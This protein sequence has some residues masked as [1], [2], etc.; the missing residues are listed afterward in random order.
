M[1]IA[2]ITTVMLCL[3]L[4]GAVYTFTC[5]VAKLAEVAEAQVEIRA[6]LS[7]KVDEKALRAI[8]EQL[9]QIPGIQSFEYISKEKALERM[10][11]QFGDKEGLLDGIDKINPLPASFEIKVAEPSMLSGVAETVKALSGID[12]VDYQKELVDKLLLVTRTMRFGSVLVVVGL[13]VVTIFL[14]ANTIRLTVYARRKEIA[15]MKLVGATDSLVRIPLVL[16]GVLLG[17]VGGIAAG[18]INNVVYAYVFKTV[19]SSMPFI[20]LVLPQ[21][22]NGKVL[23]ITAG[24]GI[25]IGMV[26][27]VV[28]M[29]RFLRI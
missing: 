2:S 29:R 8:Q 19:S 7:P 10:K 15:I 9:K 3:L 14:I 27:S 17:V 23:A 16:E 5:K 11:Q 26:G 28:S 18:L 12:E 1:T 22:V 13:G 20:P 25:V 21:A 24:A 6:Y 4:L